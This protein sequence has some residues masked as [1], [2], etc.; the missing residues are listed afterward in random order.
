MVRLLKK[1]FNASHKNFDLFLGKYA[2][3]KVAKRAVFDEVTHLAMVT[4]VGQ[5]NFLWRMR[6]AARRQIVVFP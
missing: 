4:G 5:R 3:D 2:P 6:A 1:S